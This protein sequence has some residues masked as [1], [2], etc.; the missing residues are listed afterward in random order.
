MYY[1]VVVQKLYNK[2]SETYWRKM[3]RGNMPQPETV[4]WFRLRRKQLGYKFRRQYSVD[5]YVVDFY[6]P[7]FRLAIEIDGDSHFTMKAKRY[8]AN[9]QAL[10]EA[11]GISILR[12][13]ND[14]V[15]KNVDGVLAAILERIKTNPH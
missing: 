3:L 4:L 12:F 6:C 10:I 9:R 14:E 8:D 1:G 15:M 7:E 11:C 13:T 5:S 2:A